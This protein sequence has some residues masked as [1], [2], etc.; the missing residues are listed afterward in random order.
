MMHEGCQVNFPTTGGK[1]E[2]RSVDTLQDGY[3]C[4]ATRQRETAHSSRAQPGGQAKKAPSSS[5]D[6]AWNSHSPFK[7]AQDNSPRSPAKLLHTTSCSAVV[8]SQSHHSSHSLIN[9]FIVCN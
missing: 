9:N 1:L 8:W 2:L 6:F 3:N 4:P 5:W 7:C